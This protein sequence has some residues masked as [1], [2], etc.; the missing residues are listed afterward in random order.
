MKYKPI[1][2]LIGCCIYPVLGHAQDT[3]KTHI[4]YDLTTEVAVGTGDF[5]AYQLA[6]NQHHV[7]GTRSNTAYMRGALQIRHDIS[8]DWAISELTLLAPLMQII[9][10][11]CSNAM[12]TCLIKNSSWKLERE[13]NTRLFVMKTYP[14]VHL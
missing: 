6:T 14:L 13:N 12:P 11:F 3:L 9:R 4:T 10:H 7:L 2:L 5:T 8:H 1:L